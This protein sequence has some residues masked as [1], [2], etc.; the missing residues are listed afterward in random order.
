M[1]PCCK[2][3]SPF[4][5]TKQEKLPRRG[6]IVFWHMRHAMYNEDFIY[7]FEKE[8]ESM[9]REEGGIKEGEGKG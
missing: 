1:L 6:R 9:R 7:L 5:G 2:D 8:R 3:A 4:S